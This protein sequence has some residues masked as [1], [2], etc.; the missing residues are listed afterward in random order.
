MITT[1]LQNFISRKNI[2]FHCFQ[3]FIN[4]I[5]YLIESSN[6]T[7][8]Y[9]IIENEFKI[10]KK[11][12][13]IQSINL[14]PW[15]NLFIMHNFLIIKWN[16]PYLNNDWVSRIH[17]LLW[18]IK[19]LLLLFF[20]DFRNSKKKI[21]GLNNFKSSSFLTEESVSIDLNAA[22][23][24]DVAVLRCLY[25]PQWCEEGVYWALQFLYHRF[26]C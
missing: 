16:I 1:L 12:I 14:F 18:C 22:T 9:K 11:K 20:F 2:V 4:N 17:K 15:N 24:L 8:T 7:S 21:T 6:N 10:S 23:F 19:G 26:V 13:I 5:H 3:V 25:V